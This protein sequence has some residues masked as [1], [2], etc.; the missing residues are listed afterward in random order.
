MTLP[1]PGP[2]EPGGAEAKI[3]AAVLSGETG[4]LRRAVPGDE[5]SGLAATY[6]PRPVGSALTI[7]ADL[8][9]GVDIGSVARRLFAALDATGRRG[10]A[11]PGFGPVELMRASAAE[12]SGDLLMGQ[13]LHYLGMMVADTLGA[14]GGAVGAAAAPRT[15]RA[16]RTPGRGGGRRGRPVR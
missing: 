2:C 16:E 7:R 14:C 9:P 1:A 4:P 5:A 10:L 3:I 8:L 13:R 6:V 12:R 11:E 15:K